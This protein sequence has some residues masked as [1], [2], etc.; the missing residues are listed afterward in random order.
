[1]RGM[2]LPPLPA[3]P[4][5]IHECW[6]LYL[7]RL[8][9]GVMPFPEASQLLVAYMAWP[10]DRRNRDRWMATNIAFFIAEQSWK[11]SEPT[12]TEPARRSLPP[13]Y[14]AFELFGGLR[15]VA[16]ASLSHMMRELNTIQPRWPRVADV[17]QM[18]VDISHEKRAP[19]T[20][21]ASVSKALD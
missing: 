20:G 5:T 7:R 12:T 1:M 15:T 18:V 8:E 6:K 11:P 4:S 17:L 16:D 9:H 2:N 10:N 14:S 3:P 19:I 21:G 13:E